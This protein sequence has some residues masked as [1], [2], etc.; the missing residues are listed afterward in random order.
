[1]GRWVWHH[2]KGTGNNKLV[3]LRA[4]QVCRTSGEQ[5]TYK[6]QWH[7][8]HDKDEVNPEPHHQLFEDLIPQVLMVVSKGPV[9][10]MLDVNSK[11]DDKDYLDFLERTYLH[12][13]L[14][15]QC[16]RPYPPMHNWGGQLDAILGTHQLLPHN[17]KVGVLS[18]EMGIS[19]SNHFGIFVDFNEQEVFNNVTSDPTARSK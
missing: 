13:L 16:D 14:E 9:I 6:Q 2:L 11:P 19:T 5:T 7:Y 12:K 8:M 18:K 15:I 3:I 10:V 17:E 1:M 4:Y